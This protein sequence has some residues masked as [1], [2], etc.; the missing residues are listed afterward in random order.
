METREKLKKTGKNSQ[1][2]GKQ[3]CSAA[4]DSTHIFTYTNITISFCMR[5]LVSRFWLAHIKIY[6]LVGVLLAW[7]LDSCPQT[8]CLVEAG[9]R[10]RVK[11]LC[12]FDS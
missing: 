9:V 8:K 10:G 11:L 5:W 2:W 3:Q 12:P 4:N 7:L 6:G 1:K